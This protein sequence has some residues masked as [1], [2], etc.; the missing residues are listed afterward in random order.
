MLKVNAASMEPVK[1]EGSEIKE[2]ETFTYL[3]CIIDKHG[4]TDAYVNARIGK[5]KET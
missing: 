2:I 1:L 3:D 5:A 4:G